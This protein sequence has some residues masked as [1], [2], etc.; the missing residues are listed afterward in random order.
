MPGTVGTTG[1][2]GIPRIKPAVSPGYALRKPL[3]WS[4]R[5]VGPN[6]FGRVVRCGGYARRI[7]SDAN[8]PPSGPVD[9]TPHQR[10]STVAYTLRKSIA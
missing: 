10:S 4:E 5:F 9:G 3:L 2:P 1:D 6:S 8:L 7:G